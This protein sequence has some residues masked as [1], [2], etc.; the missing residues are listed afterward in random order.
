VRHR[1]YVIA[2]LAAV[3]LLI[4]AIAARPSPPPLTRLEAI[5]VARG[6]LV[7]V[8]RQ[9]GAL[10]PRAPTL[11]K[12]PMQARLQTVVTD[13]AWVEPGQQLFVLGDDEE[14]KRAADERS[15]LLAARQELRLARLRRAHADAEEAQKLEASQRA[16]ELERL[17]NRIITSMPVG[18]DELLRLDAALTPLEAGTAA[19]RDA[20][21]QAHDAWQRA[22]DAHLD[23][24]DTLQDARDDALRAQAKVDELATRVE[25]APE[26]LGAAERA[27]RDLAVASLDAARADLAAAE[28]AMAGRA[29]LV[30]TARA[31][32]DA[33]APA[34][35]ATAAALAERETAELDLRVRLEIEKR[36]LPLT[37]L[38]LDRESA[39]LSLAEAERKRDDGRAAFA[40]GALARS[41]LDDLESAAA[42]RAG[43]LAM[44]DSRIAIASRPLTPEAA[45][46]AKV[47]LDRA[48]AT[49][50]AAQAAR[51]RA[52]GILDQEL[53]VLEAREKRLTTQIELRAY[54]FPSMLESAIEFAEKELAA[55]DSEEA[56]GLTI[57]SAERRAVL[58]AE[59][60]RLRQRLEVAKAAPPNVILAPSAGVVRVGRQDDRAKQAGDRV[61][62]EDVVVELFAPDDMEVVAKINEVDVE[63]VRPGMR[64]AVT[65]PALKDRAVGGV[66]ERVSGIGK[67]KLAELG[68]FAD[69]VQFDLRIK[70][71]HGDPEFR[72]GM[73][74]LVAIDA[75]A[76]ADVLW[77]PLGAVRAE[78]DGGWTVL[79]GDPAERAPVRG[80]PFAEDRFIIADGLAEGDTV[81]VERTRNE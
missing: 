4:I 55:V 29:E 60:Q 49:A 79:T 69:V 80:E 57:D 46:E 78:A 36:G 48:E 54:A 27:E 64:C 37:K 13:G 66:V 16:V 44:L 71:D 10:S 38:V 59:L 56:E 35:D 28:A 11:I 81:F 9:A 25:V 42:D 63:R 32:R 34:R 7:H 67:D 51:D 33:A 65:I 1:R 22:F 74:A 73:T 70:L 26:D 61:S 15:Q 62:E 72:Q 3:A 76:R 39:A 19:A 5:A 77:L 47:T 2:A 53:A 31:A 12:S 23:A 14:L 41:A 8:L 45:A 43:E 30:A 6:D 75:G 40:A 52:L 58:G 50:A 20:Y 68:G 24:L 17:R 21:E 18:G